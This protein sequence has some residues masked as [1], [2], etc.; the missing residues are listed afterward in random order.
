MTAIGRVTVTGDMIFSVGGSTI[1]EEGIGRLGEIDGDY[2][3]L[4]YVVSLHRWLD[5]I[6]GPVF[7]DTSPLSVVAR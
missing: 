1:G 4:E 5:P 2:N 6:S 7:I 3:L